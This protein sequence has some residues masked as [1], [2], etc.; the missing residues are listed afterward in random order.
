M[1]GG[2]LCLLVAEKEF[3]KKGKMRGEHERK[4]FYRYGSE[5]EV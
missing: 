3:Q 4:F 2:V 1:N 5:S